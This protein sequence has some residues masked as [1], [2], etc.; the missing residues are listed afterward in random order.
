MKCEKCGNYIEDINDYCDECGAKVTKRKYSSIKLVLLFILE[1]I[2]SVS[3]IISFVFIVKNSIK[4]LSP[5]KFNEILIENSY[6]VENITKKYSEEKDI[7]KYFLAKNKKYDIYF[8]YLLM[9][10]NQNKLFNNLVQKS[11]TEFENTFIQTNSINFHN[12]KY[13]SIENSEN[14]AVVIENEN[15]IIWVGGNKENKQKI[16]N[17]INELNIVYPSIANFLLVAFILFIAIII[18]VVQWKIFV[19]AKLKGWYV[20][21]PLYNDY[22]F[23]KIAFG[24]GWNFIFMYITPLN[25]I[26]IPFLLYKFA[27]AFEKSILFSIL[28][29]IFPF[30]NM[31]IIAFD[32]SSYTK[33]KTL[34]EKISKEKLNEEKVSSD[35]LIVYDKKQTDD[36]DYI[37]ENKISIDDE[38]NNQMYNKLFK[39]QHRSSVLLCLSILFYFLSM[40]WL[41]IFSNVEEEQEL[42]L[43]IPFLIIIAIATILLI[44]SNVIKPKNGRIKHK[45]KNEKYLFISIILF[46]INAFLIN[47]GL[48]C[49]DISVE[50][51]VA[52][53]VAELG[54]AVTSLVYY[55]KSYSYKKKRLKTW[56]KVILFIISIVIGFLISIL[57]MDES[58]VNDDLIF[59]YSKTTDTIYEQSDRAIT[60]YKSDKIWYTFTNKYNTNH[61]EFSVSTTPENLFVVYETDN[62]NIVNLSGNDDYAVW[63]EI[64]SENIGYYYYDVSENQVYEL[65]VM[66]YTKNMKQAFS[67]EIYKDNIYYEVIDN[68]AKKVVVMEYNIT[69][70]Q[71]RS[72]YTING[73]A[74]DN[75]V[76]N[77]INI[78]GNYLLINSF[79]N[80][81]PTIIKLDLTQ[82]QNE[83]YKT[84]IIVLKENI[85]DIYAISYD[86]NKYMIYYNKDGR[87]MIEMIDKE[88]SIK[89]RIHT[90]ANKEYIYSDNIYLKNNMLYYIKLNEKISTNN[91]S[92]RTKLVI[93]DLKNNK[94]QEIKGIFDYCITKKT[95]YGLGTYKNNL[96][97]VRLYEIWN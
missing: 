1:I 97:N 82:K 79:V 81:E 5:N 86:D 33:L 49:I 52:I 16:N 3:L 11:N 13:Y 92:E 25:I 68:N 91:M 36:L 54:L 24:K 72:I 8:H 94:K 40:S 12:Y 77:N 37:F 53:W 71:I 46:G 4:K 61:Y 27:R 17:I 93:Y 75:L 34:K 9:N 90:F 59:D 20:F 88:G 2:I 29:I 42:L 14:Y 23:A 84:N 64:G 67:I 65:L 41:F 22:L 19:K 28:N 96:K 95:I 7:D 35:E 87:D 85:S 26:Y 30:I 50:L 63:C 43:L 80:N 73:I 66:P 45:Y 62:V 6:K 47:D 48:T 70:N 60:F 78:S 57:V 44:I 76:K 89:K 38:S 32:N 10:K 31:Q 69:S 21:I 39:S 51:E 15:A 18:K 74:D 56:V 83:S 58:K 55:F